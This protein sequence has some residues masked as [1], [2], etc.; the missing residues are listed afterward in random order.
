MSDAVQRDSSRRL[1]GWWRWSRS[2]WCWSTPSVTGSR[3]DRRGGSRAARNEIIEE[4]KA[5]PP[6]KPPRRRRQAAMP[7]RRTFPRRGD[8]QARWC[9][10][11]LS[12]RSRTSSRRRS[13]GR[14]RWSTPTPARSR[15]TPGGAA[16]ERNRYRRL[17]FLIDRGRQGAG[18]QGRTQQAF[19]GPRRAQGPPPGLS[20]VRSTLL[21]STLRPRRS[22]SQAHDTGFVRPPRRR[23]VRR[24]LAGVG[25]DT[26]GVHTPPAA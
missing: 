19:P 20:R 13:I 26:A 14:R 4:I 7:P 17:T 6:D 10:H 1:P 15:R 8:V 22:G 24:L 23:G 25:V 12:P 3:A 5:P 2:T 11:P 9:S 16:G 18:Q 21:S